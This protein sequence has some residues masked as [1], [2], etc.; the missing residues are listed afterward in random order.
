VDT[1]PELPL[2]AIDLIIIPDPLQASDPSLPK[3]LSRG[4]NVDVH[5]QHLVSMVSVS[6]LEECVAT[7]E[8]LP[9]DQGN[10]SGIIEPD[11]QVI[12]YEVHA[13]YL[14]VR[15]TMQ[16]HDWSR[17]H[18][19]R[20]FAQWYK[21]SP[22]MTAGRCMLTPSRIIQKITSNGRDCI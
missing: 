6:W 15:D 8:V 22:R 1:L 5:A 3:S 2:L 17:S 14:K 7:Q 16:E 19:Q 12:P 20:F 10:P 4:A 11:D 18:C 21:A 9:N 13:T